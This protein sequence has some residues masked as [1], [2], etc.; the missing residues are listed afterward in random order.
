MPLNSKENVSEGPRTESNRD[1]ERVEEL[2]QQVEQL[3]KRVS[4]VENASKERMDGLIELNDD[5][6]EQVEQQEEVI[7]ELVEAVEILA[8]SVD[9]NNFADGHTVWANEGSDAYPF[10]W[11]GDV[12]DFKAKRYE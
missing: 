9:A 12:L 10:D 1:S 4:A 6:R 8:A 11:P 5:L 2:E 7:H 3:H